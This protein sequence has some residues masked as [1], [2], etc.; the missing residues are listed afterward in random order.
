[1]NNIK[2]IVFDLYNTLIEIK[3]SNNF[4]LKLFKTSKN[5]FGLNVI[6]YLE[7][8]MT[9]EIDDV[10]TILPIE[11][12]ELYYKNEVD[13]EKELD[14]IVVYKEVFS[15]LEELKKDFQIFLISNLASPYKKPVFETNL[16]TYFDGLFF[17]CDYGAL[18]PNERIFKEV[19]K[20]TGNTKNEIVMIGDSF[21]SDVIGA[22]NIGWKYL[23]INRRE[24]L[25][26]EYEISDLS[27]IKKQIDVI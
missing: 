16:Y 21:K 13:L 20:F 17:S 2:I 27:Q 15:V 1:M 23:K 26:K 8:I 10:M 12:K 9:R 19:E 5:G 24:K 3:E 6:A 25:L 18:K 22:K 11:F 7:L 4:F 14:S